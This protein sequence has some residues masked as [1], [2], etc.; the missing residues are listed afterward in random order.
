MSDIYNNMY[1]FALGYSDNNRKD[2]IIYRDKR[3]SFH[4]FSKK[5][6]KCAMQFAATGIGKGDCVAICLPNIPQAQIAF[7][8]CAK[9]GAIAS[10]V[11]PKT[12][13]TEFA[14]QVELT[15]PKLALLT[16]IN[17]FRFKPMLK[18]AKKVFCSLISGKGFVG[19][20]RKTKAYSA[21][22]GNGNE[23]AIYMHSGGTTGTSKTVV[24]SSRAMNALVENL[25]ESLKFPFSEKDKMLAALP[26]FHGFGL[27]VGIHLAL[28][29]KMASALV[30]IFKPKKV[31]E[32][33][34]K[35]RVNVLTV[36]PRMLQK[37]LDEPSFHGEVVKQ[38]TN[39]YVGGDNL[40]EELRIAFNERMQQEGSNCKIQQGYGLTEMGSVC[41]LNYDKIKPDS[42]GQPL[43]NVQAKI[44]DDDMAELPFGDVGEL[45]FK[46]EQMMD[47]YL[48]DE[49]TTKNSFAVI[50]GEK[51]LRTG[52]FMSMDK[53]GF[54][55]FKGRKKRLIKISGMNVFPLQIEE[56]ARQLDEISLCV[57]T[58]K[59]V[60]GKPYICLYVLLKDGLVLDERL[61]AKFTEF[62]EKNLSHWSV[63]KF[64]EQLEEMPYTNFGKVDFKEIAKKC[65]AKLA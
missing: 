3:I 9:I 33:L 54:L 65:E 34:R 42:V 35:Q 17:Y 24:L 39:V 4:E 57:A 6:E 12:S 48:N 29:S 27:A 19:L 58:Q 22:E 10:M 62:L 31:V 49:E 5:V 64:Y 20:T 56:T 21:N 26:I 25:L 63:P 45:I 2:A 60:E 7:Y 41:T 37:I 43:F 1:D 14:R 16:E 53:E 23:P 46:S 40:T 32:F 59:D 15:K 13:A 44:I 11:H 36:I 30:P 18:G 51:W 61:K 50:D 38:L 52:D 47:G 8:A 55:F 28:C